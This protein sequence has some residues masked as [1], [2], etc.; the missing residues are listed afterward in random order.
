MLVTRHKEF[1]SICFWVF[2]EDRALPFEETNRSAVDAGSRFKHLPFPFK[3]FAYCIASHSFLHITCAMR[4]AVPRR[5]G[6]FSKAPAGRAVE[7]PVPMGSKSTTTLS[8]LAA[9]S[10]VS[11]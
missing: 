1:P 2:R 9:P 5:P 8:S 4:D 11:R 3:L 7:F 6:D 10:S